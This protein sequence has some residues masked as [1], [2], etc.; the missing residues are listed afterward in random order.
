MIKREFVQDYLDEDGFK[1]HVPLLQVTKVNASLFVQYE[2]ESVCI[3]DDGYSWLQHFPEGA[4]HS[5]TTMF[6]AAGEVVQWY[7]D[8]CY[9]NGIENGRP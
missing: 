7:I 3:V 6:N 1:G 8:I 4:Q 2:D 5:V 9:Q